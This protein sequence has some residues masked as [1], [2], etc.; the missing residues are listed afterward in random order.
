MR[1]QIV[2]NSHFYL[3]EIL[4]SYLLMYNRIYINLF[5]L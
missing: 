1:L 2:Q 4:I 3:G 5:G